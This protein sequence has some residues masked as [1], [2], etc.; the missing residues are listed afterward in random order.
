MRILRFSLIFVCSLLAGCMGHYWYKPISAD[1]GYN[2]NDAGGYKDYLI[3]I[4]TSV[5]TYDGDT[6]TSLSRIKQY[7]LY[8]AAEV[9]IAHNY[10]YFVVVSTSPS[11]FVM[12][13]ITPEYH[14]YLKAPAVLYPYTYT[15]N[16]YTAFNRSYPGREFPRFTCYPNKAVVTIEMF[17]GD[18]PATQPYAFNALDVVAETDHSILY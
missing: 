9:T 12:P 6:R 15:P 2:Y 11:P 13:L 5:I 7:L 14:K 8:R 4:N 16:Q 1:R 3:N 10:D 18:V 17:Q